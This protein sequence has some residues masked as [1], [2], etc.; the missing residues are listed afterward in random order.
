M[1]LHHVVTLVVLPCLRDVIDPVSEI[2]QT[3]NRKSVSLSTMLMAIDS[4]L[5]KAPRPYESRK[6]TL[7]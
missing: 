3:W 1:Q 2:V 7:G 4:F 5:W 6:V